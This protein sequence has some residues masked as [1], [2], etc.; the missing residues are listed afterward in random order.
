M[1]TDNIEEIK[2][3]IDV[4]ELLQEYIQLKPAGTN[5]FKALCP[6]HHEKTPSFVVSKDKQIWHCFGCGEG[7]DIFG[8]LM[9]ME[10]LEFPEALR[11]LA[12]KAGVQLQYRDPALQNQKTKLL[13][14]IKSATAFYH[15]ILLDHPKAQPVRDY[16]KKRQ[17]AD[18]SV[19]TWQ[20]GFAPDAWETL[21]NYLVQRGFKEDDIFLAGLTVKKD[22]GVGYY[23][24][25]R[26][27]L[28]F[29]IADVHGNIIG[30][31]GRWLGSETD[32]QAAKYVNTPQTLVYNKSHVLY[33]LDRA[34]QSIKEQQVAV[35]VEGY[36][37]CLTSHQ[38]GVTN[39]V[40][41]SG[42]ALTSEQLKLL[43]RFT[44]NV[45][46]AFDQD[47]AG[48]DASRRGIDV[49]WREE[50]ETKII[51]LPFGK[52]PDELVKK[53]PAAWR[54]AITKAQSIMEYYF[55]ATLS[56]AD[57]S[58]V[59]D[60]KK[61][62][63]TLL[64][65]IVKLVDPIEQTHYLQKLGDLLGVKEDVLRDKLRQLSLKK[66]NTPKEPEVAGQV[67]K[68]RFAVLGEVIVGLVLRFPE[69]L[70]LVAEQLLPEYLSLPKLQRLYKSVIV[71]YTKNQAFA[72]S[73]F[74]KS[75]SPAEKDLSMYAEILSLKAE[76]D[77]QEA[78]DETIQKELLTGT[79]DLQRHYIQNQLREI[80][81][82]LR[83]AERKHDQPHVEEYSR[84]FTEL[85]S[86]LGHL[87]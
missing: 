40:A 43:K 61:V 36:M 42:T 50:M 1:P 59:E 35:V 41:S 22:R 46:F 63:R 2:S 75:L 5:S 20:L 80:E 12:K 54:E 53:D 3:K 77:I 37:D 24:R 49:A 55:E 9:K 51:R 39:V 6:F 28:M 38:A 83:Q 13:D 15:K 66:I 67:A 31:G 65:V 73:D 18:E 76:H 68:D 44:R 14:I 86:A 72:Y 71:Y 57:L 23:D 8:F 60:K 19:E 81:Q 32:A 10:G 69:H 30:F 85:M 74:L 16:L 47:I 70:G 26:N 64:G 25:F 17:V 78:D 52:D 84:K 27:R 82:L 62:A 45:A 33:G 7:G 48:E 79:K 21:N 87:M 11:V 58:K 56:K 34:K 29:P 4:V